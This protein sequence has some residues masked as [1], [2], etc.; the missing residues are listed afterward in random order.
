MKIEISKTNLNI[1]VEILSVNGW[2]A[3]ILEDLNSEEEIDISYHAMGYAQNVRKMQTF[4][5]DYIE[6]LQ[7]DSKNKDLTKINTDDSIEFACHILD[8]MKKGEEL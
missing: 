6:I 4:L 8:E 5:N 7:E 1:L 2:F 3:Q